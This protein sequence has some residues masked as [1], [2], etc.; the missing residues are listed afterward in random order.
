MEEFMPYL[1][2]WGKRQYTLKRK[3]ER[4]DYE[5]YG[6]FV[7]P[8][9]EQYA[10]I[11]LSFIRKF[12]FQQRA[13]FSIP[14]ILGDIHELVE[15]GLNEKNVIDQIAFVYTFDD[16]EDI[17]KDPG[18]NIVK[19]EGY[20]D[21]EEEIPLTRS[22]RKKLL[23]KEK[24]KTF[25][26]EE[27]EAK[28]RERVYEDEQEWERRFEALENFEKDLV[29]ELGES[30]AE[31]AKQR[32]TTYFDDPFETE[33][34][35]SRS[36]GQSM[37]LE[38]PYESTVRGP[39]SMATEKSGTTRESLL[40]AALAAE[41][42]PSHLSITQAAI[43]VASEISPEPIDLGDISPISTPRYQG[44]SLPTWAP[45]PYLPPMGP[46]PPLP[47]RATATV[48]VQTPARLPAQINPN[49]NIMRLVSV[50][51][52]FDPVTKHMTPIEQ[53]NM[54]ITLRKLVEEGV[55]DKDVKELLKETQSRMMEKLGPR[56]V[57]TNRL[58]HL[59]SLAEHY[60]PME[61]TPEQTTMIWP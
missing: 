38:P 23:E 27:E 34:A 6:Q 24:V 41:P 5:V 58:A 26:Q 10:Q 43:A 30:R 9:G 12:P 36:I 16:P 4:E 31:I 49:T 52:L 57:G 15:Q 21:E 56:F 20:V 50:G 2:D 53:V 47:P 42:E 54:N 60:R 1:K 18:V 59:R 48:T 28:E 17:A 8:R 32:N 3:Y 14:V 22:R 40:Q 51:H 55:D 44:P 45:P 39:R 25:Q 13:E 46:P 61:T 11:H 7:P 19:M 37:S 33:S 29:K 35:Q